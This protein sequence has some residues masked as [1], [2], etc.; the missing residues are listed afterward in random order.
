MSLASIIESAER[1]RTSVVY[2][3]PV[4]DDFGSQFATRNVDITYRDLPPD[5]PDAFV[6]VR[7]GERFRGAVS[8]ETLREFLRP[9][10]RHPED[11]DDLSS[12]Y[13][14]VFELLDTTVFGTLSR[15]QLL[16]TA[17]E[18]EDRAYRVGRGTFHVGFQ[19]VAAF[20]AQRT[21]YR[22]LAERTDLDIHVHV[23]PGAETESL[24]GL[25]LRVHVQPD[26]DTGRYWFLVFDGAGEDG[27]KCALVAEQRG[28]DEYYGTWTYDPALVDRALEAVS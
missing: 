6:V 16:A 14:A 26:A 3:R 18:I 8:A 9:P 2:Y 27:G 25:S 11:P 4:P 23:V 7:D 15:R 5:G 19:S 10:L 21:L 24:R 17:R 13:R 28:P 22:R 1:H 20:D 12:A